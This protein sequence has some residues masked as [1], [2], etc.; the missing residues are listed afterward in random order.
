MIRTDIVIVGSRVAGSLV[1]ANQAR[2]GVGRGIL[3][4]GP[5]NERD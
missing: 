5:S 4:A 3:E 2:A 1:G